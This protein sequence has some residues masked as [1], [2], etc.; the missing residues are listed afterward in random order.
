M[1]VVG[2]PPRGVQLREVV[3]HPARDEPLHQLL[4]LVAVSAV[5]IVREAVELVDRPARRL[6]LHLPRV[7]GGG[8]ERERQGARMHGVPVDAEEEGV[9]HH[10]ADAA[11][12]EAL[13]GVLLEEEVDEVAG[14][15][16]EEGWE[17][18]GPLHDVAEDGLGERRGAAR[19]FTESPLKGTTPTMSW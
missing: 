1:H 6:V 15:R 17:D 11:V 7:H 5:H 2:E 12:A 9:G 14:L 16:R 3:L 10:I 19:T 13:R 18:D 8:G 4:L